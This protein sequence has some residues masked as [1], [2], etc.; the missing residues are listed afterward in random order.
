MA[1]KLDRYIAGNVAGSILLML[2]LVVGLDAVFAF[3]DQLEDL[4][5]DY[6]T[7]Q[8]LQYVGLTLFKR[9]YEFTPMATLIGCLFGLGILASSNEL[10]VM[11]AAGMSIN[12]IAWA[13]VKPALVFVVT[14]IL[15]GE[16]VVP[17]SEP[18]AQTQRVLAQS[19]GDTLNSREGFWHR[20]GNTFMHFGAVLPGGVI[21]GVTQ[22]SFDDDSRLIQSRYARKGLYQGDHWNLQDVV[23]THLSE[24]QSRVEK[25]VTQRWD[26]GLTPAVLN[27]IV[28]KPEDLST[29]GLYTYSN[30]LQE[31]GLNAKKY[32]LAFWKKV[33]QPLAAV[34]M[35]LV[36]LSCIFGPLRS[37]TMG[38][39][40]FLGVILGMVFKYSE[41]FMAPASIVFGFD[42]LLASLLPISVF[43]VAAVVLLRRA[44]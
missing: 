11:R 28:V 24:Q 12:R 6:Q 2:V 41:D 38:F 43:F 31:Q 23:I 16:Y 7:L 29:Q 17:Y 25:H 15:I 22:Y 5:G 1:K 8:A 20:E 42:P 3:T 9:V 36:A 21:Y 32:L 14:A 40:I 39:R 26:T 30:Y 10:T 19:E 33:F 4:E 44:A 18:Y 13:V 35:V 37:S 27:V 34:V